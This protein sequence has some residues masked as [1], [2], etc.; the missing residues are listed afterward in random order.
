[1]LEDLLTLM[2]LPLELLTPMSIPQELLTQTTTLT[3]HLMI[4]IMTGSLQCHWVAICP[5][6]KDLIMGRRL[7]GVLVLDLVVAEVKVTLTR[8]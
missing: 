5:L 2:S 4:L 1:M 7:S 8:K 3:F 6:L